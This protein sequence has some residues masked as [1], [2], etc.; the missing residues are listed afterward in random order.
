M[1][2]GRRTNLLANCK[3]GILFS[4][5]SW[6]RTFLHRCK[7]PRPIPSWEKAL[8]SYLLSLLSFL[9]STKL[10]TNSSPLVFAIWLSQPLNLQSCTSYSEAALA[11]SHMTGWVTLD[12]KASST[13][14][15]NIHPSKQ[16]V[17]KEKK[18]KLLR[19]WNRWSRPALLHELGQTLLFPNSYSKYTSPTCP[20]LDGTS[21]V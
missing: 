2:S 16:Q 11:W 21:L 5:V 1:S 4:C 7:A 6:L 18:K 20:F 13:F 15:E 8:S 9:A 3:C 10:K 14:S 19:T 12:T 17:K